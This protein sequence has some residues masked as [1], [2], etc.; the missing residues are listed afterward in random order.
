MS[1]DTLIGH[2]Q[3]GNP[4]PGSDIGL[5][6]LKDGMTYSIV[7]FDGEEVDGTNLQGF[8][9]SQNLAIGESLS[10]DSP[11]N[12]RCEGIL[13]WR[14][15]NVT[16]DPEHPEF[17]Y[18]EVCMVYFGNGASDVKF[19]SCGSAIWNDENQVGA[20]FRWYDPVSAVAYAPSVDVLI[21]AG[22]TLEAIP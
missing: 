6:E 2:V 7:S 18:V 8:V 13:G 21:E 15:V 19:G 16:I 17:T 4:F 3:D 20:F 9:Y 5:T 10:M 11:Y 1:G 12:G 22:Y 14:G